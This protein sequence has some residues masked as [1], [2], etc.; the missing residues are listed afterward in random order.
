LAGKVL[1]AGA[2]ERFRS[3]AALA[4]P[5]RPFAA[6]R[7]RTVEASGTVKTADTIAR[8]KAQGKQVVS[9][10]VGEPDFDTPADIRDA[11]KKALD[12]GMTHYTSSYGLP[13]LREAIA[14]KSRDENHI[15][16]EARHV[17]VTPAK[18]AIFEAILACIDP[19]DEVVLTDPAWV[20]YEPIIRLAGGKPV[21]VRVDARKDFRMR[22]EDVAS[23]LTPKTKLL[24]ANSPNNPTG[25]VLRDT[26]VRGLC[27]LAK[28][29]DLWVLSDEIYE[30]MVYDG[31]HLSFAAQDGMF[32]RTITVNGFS[33]AYAMTGWR[34]GWLV[35]PE[36]ALNEVSKLQQHSITHCTSFAMAGGIAA[37]QGPQQ[38]VH[39]MVAEFQAR[40]DLVVDGLNRIPGF[41]CVRP[42]GAFYVFPSYDVPLSSQEF[43]DVLLREAGVAVTPGSSFGRAGEGHVRISYAASRATIQ[44]GLERIRAACAS[45]G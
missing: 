10:T 29:H 28:D 6:Q 38:S 30:K 20:S 7:M 24:I 3:G 32:E 23:V 9:F 18:Q 19:G 13:A 1:R 16:C 34:L 26:D 5:M 40:R 22:P 15:P 33:K 11:A 2:P 21:A 31:K 42:Q 8:L 43:A 39:A 45:L 36:P 35:A 41:R 44:E 17:L 4:R 27:D 12:E 25:S 37:L 14:R